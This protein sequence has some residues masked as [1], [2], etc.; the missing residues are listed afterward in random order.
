MNPTTLDPRPNGS[1]WNVETI[2]A[3]DRAVRMVLADLS[4]GSDEEV[5]AERLLS[6]R[7]AELLATTAREVRVAPGTV[8]T[9]LARDL[10]KSRGITLRVV[11]KA[12]VKTSGEWAFAFEAD[13]GL[14]AALRRTLLED[15]M[16]WRE[17]KTEELARWL[18]GSDER[19]ALLVTDEASVAVWR[20]N[21]RRGVRAALAGDPTA[22]AKAVRSLGV[23]LLVVEPAGKSINLMRQIVLTFRKAGAPRVPS[24]L[25][26]EGL[27]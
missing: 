14:L 23:N 8:I 27:S 20:A 16:A 21:Q 5:F 12:E 22:V 3:V 24:G 6:L 15:S 1:R 2:E 26:A 17:I 9:P 7:H 11:S 13:S 18:A 25:I 10:L 4:R 19:G